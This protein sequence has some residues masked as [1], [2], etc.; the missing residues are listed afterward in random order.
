MRRLNPYLFVC[1]VSIVLMFSSCATMINGIRQ[2]VELYST[3]DS[4]SVF[5]NGEDINMV[6]PCVVKVKR[7]QQ[8]GFYNSRNEHRF[9]L[10]KKGYKDLEVTIKAKINPMIST[11]VGLIA[12][13]LLVDPLNWSKDFDQ[14]GELFVS[15]LV[16]VPAGAL[17]DFA[18]GATLKYDK[19]IFAQM[20]PISGKSEN[21]ILLKQPSEVISGGGLA[22]CI[23]NS[24]YKYAGSLDNPV[25]DAN[26]MA[27]ILQKIGYHVKLYNDLDQ[28]EMR[29]AIDE[30]G[31]ELKNYHVGLFFFAGHGIQAKGNN[32]LIPVDANIGS[33]SEVEYTCVNAGRVL[34]RMESAGTI[35]NI[36]ILDA[37]RN[38]PFERSWTRSTVGRGL[39][40]MDAPVGSLIGFA[41]S[42]GKTASDGYGR[43]G[44]YTGAI[45]N[46]I[47]EPGLTI[48][49]L[50]QK[51]RRTVR[52]TSDGEQVPWEST[53]LEGN[54]Y[55]IKE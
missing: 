40:V 24:D 54:Y 29:R 25:N 21:F 8:P 47:Q 7:R 10:K 31:N 55:F 23:G 12:P 33:E 52:E 27:A 38:N 48:I 53:S 36:I 13:G 20:E 17:V 49:E 6:T 5:L 44:L 45:L 32:Y 1:L 51:V 18:T 42:P 43:N 41:T 2:K 26:D 50:L 34:G 11:N 22:L 30:F 37:C 3:P 14:P 39:A 9:V 4:A 16:L 35:T 46:H 19:R 28:D 15:S